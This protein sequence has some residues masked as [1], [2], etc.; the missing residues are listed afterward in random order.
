MNN[1]KRVLAALVLAGAALS[2]TTAAHADT[3]DRDQL[4]SKIKDDPEIIDI[5]K[6]TILFNKNIFE[7]PHSAVDASILAKIKEKFPN[8]HDANSELGKKLRDLS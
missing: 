2:V 5:I 6:T 4:I 1:T 7:G 8:V 3:P